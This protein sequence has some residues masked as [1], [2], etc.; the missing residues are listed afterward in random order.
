M[1]SKKL[2]S[3]SGL[4]S[5]LLEVEHFVC[6]KGTGLE[7][8]AVASGMVSTA[9]IARAVG[10]AISNAMDVCTQIVIELGM[11]PAL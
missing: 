5:L 4:T 11:A 6:N 7:H 1:I 2:G 8:E 3:V 10:A 9:G